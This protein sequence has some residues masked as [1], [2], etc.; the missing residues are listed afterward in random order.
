MKLLPV[1]A[2]IQAAPNRF[3][4]R[5][6]GTMTK[7]RKDVRKF[8]L[9]TSILKLRLPPRLGQTSASLGVYVSRFT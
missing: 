4:R 2:A 6:S 8:N 1:D 9:E 7:V 5:T 3:L